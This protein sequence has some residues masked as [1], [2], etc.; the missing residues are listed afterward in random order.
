MVII[1][2]NRLASLGD[3]YLRKNI[4]SLA[5]IAREVRRLLN[6]VRIFDQMHGIH[7]ESGIDR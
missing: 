1:N 6:A 5:A 4:L 7:S 3:Q 2:P